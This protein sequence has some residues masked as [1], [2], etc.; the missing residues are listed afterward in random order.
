MKRIILL[1][2][3]TFNLAFGITLIPL[4][5]IISSKKDKNIIFK[6]TNP[7]KEPVAVD[8]SVLKVISTDNN[9]EERERT[10]KIS[11]YPS[12]FVLS[13]KETKKVRVKYMGSGL[14]EIEEVYRVIAKELDVD[15]SDKKEEESTGVL[16]AKIKMR[17]TYEGLLFVHKPNTKPLLSLSFQELQSVGNERAISVTITNSGT[18]SIVPNHGIYNYLVTVKGKEYQL[19]NEDMKKAEFRRVLAGKTNTFYLKHIVNLPNGKIES[20]RLE[21]K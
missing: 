20:I 12:Q 18:S 3:L 7:T 14:P 13:P 10:D 11:Y 9:K 16:R 15:V 8:I 6:V 1:L 19:Q 5:K 17:F 2:I 4:T 21:K